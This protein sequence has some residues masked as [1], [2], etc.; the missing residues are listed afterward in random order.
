[1]VRPL[2]TEFILVDSAHARWV[3]RGQAAHDFV[4]AKVLSAKAPQPTAFFVGT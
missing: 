2:R 4:T 1:M 3:H